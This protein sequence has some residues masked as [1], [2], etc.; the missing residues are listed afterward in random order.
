MNYEMIDLAASPLLLP[1]L[2]A[3]L[4]LVGLA[5][6]RGRRRHHRRGRIDPNDPSHERFVRALSA[7]PSEATGGTTEPGHPALSSA[8]MKGLSDQ[9]ALLRIGKDG[10]IA[11]AS[12]AAL[13]LLGYKTDELDG[14][15]VS[16]LVPPW[17][18]EELV[19][20]GS[21]YIE[22][23]TQ[24]F[25]HHNRLLDVLWVSSPEIDATGQMT[26]AR[27]WAMWDITERRRQQA[28]LQLAS[29]SLELLKE[30]V[31]ITDARQGGTIIYANPSL[32]EITGH[33]VDEIIGARLH[34][35]FGRDESQEGVVELIQAIERHEPCRV[36]VQAPRKDGSSYWAEVSL[37]PIQDGKGQVN[38]SISLVRDITE[39]Y[40]YVQELRHMEARERTIIDGAPIAIC[41]LDEQ[42]VI[43]SANSMF[44]GL[45]G[46]D[47]QALIGRPLSEYLPDEAWQ[48]LAPNGVSPKRGGELM[49]TRPDGDILSVLA[50]IEQLQ[51]G[52]GGPPYTAIFM[53]DISG[54]KR[55]E[56]ALADE[57]ERA[58]VTLAAIGEGVITTNDQGAVD[59]LNPVAERLTGWAKEDVA[60]MKFDQIFPLMDD[61]TREPLK[62]PIERALRLGRTAS[63]RRALLVTRDG[64]EFGL[65]ITANPIRD[66]EQRIIGA[67]MVFRDVSQMRAA[68]RQIVKEAKYDVLTGLRNRREFHNLLEQALVS[69]AE[70]DK[71]HVVGFLDL[72]KFKIINDT[73]GHDAGDEVLKQVSELMQSKLRSM[74]ILARLGGDEFALLLH[75]CP[76]PVGERIAEQIREALEG[77]RFVWHERS[78]D[79]SVSIGLVSVGADSGSVED[80][81]KMADAACYMAKEAGRNRIHVHRP[82][83]RGP[84]ESATASLWQERIQQGVEQDRFVLFARRARALSEGVSAYVEISVHLRDEA[85]NLLPEGAFMPAAERSQQAVAIEEWKISTLMALLGQV[86]D[87]DTVHALKLSGASLQVSDRLAAFIGQQAERSKVVP[88]RICFEINES[89]LATHYTRIRTL[90]GTLKEMGFRLAIDRFGYNRASFGHLRELAVDYVKIEAGIT[91]A[92]RDNPVEHILVETISRVGELMAVRVIATGVDDTALL[93]EMAGLG[94]D[95]VLG[96]AIGGSGL[97][98][99]SSLASS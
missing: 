6:L 44:A 76:L 18:R 99:E 16:R 88:G 38:H 55:A 14:K 32:E 15:A 22:R 3:L 10:I 70:Q 20:D 43:R 60:G 12:P 79:L 97:I 9:L 49:L 84:L 52:H 33:A 24:R 80:V 28:V 85:E 69:A 74:D 94:V 86:D 36:V 42:R 48:A 26:G 51:N 91:H 5:V 98:D 56:R 50:N 82:E 23:E 65:H 72:D 57:K 19:E 39:R 45:L 27:V 87:S 54:R 46:R 2:V 58:V 78:F 77:Y 73:C 37:T 66:R 29:R 8:Q 89:E 4:I 68:E 1:A 93:S 17:C 67:V 21:R 30:G 25:M 31:M 13:R 61:E 81:M 92:M 90:F 34:V 47:T 62:D 7:P 41:M 71:Q 59:Y 75:A 53:V 11:Y 40:Q 83:G 96:D 95:Y 64:R 63:T 35:L